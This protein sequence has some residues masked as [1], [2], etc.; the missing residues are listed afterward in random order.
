MEQINNKIEY[1]FILKKTG[2]PNIK[3]ERIETK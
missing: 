3:I 1:E 2:L